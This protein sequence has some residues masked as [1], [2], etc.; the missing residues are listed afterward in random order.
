MKTRLGIAIVFTF[1]LTGCGVI[2]PKETVSNKIIELKEQAFLLNDEVKEFMPNL[3]Q[4]AVE[5]FIYQI[6]NENILLIGID[7]TYDSITEGLTDDESGK[8]VSCYKLPVTFSFT[9]TVEKIEEFLRCLSAVDTKVVMNKFEVT[10]AE[11]GYDVECLVCFIGESATLGIGNNSTALSLVKKDKAVK[12]EEEIVL[13]N[14]DVNLTV[15]PSNS[16]AAAVTLSTEL[17][18]ALRSDEN[19]LIQAIANFYKE[20]GQFYCKYSIG[21]QSQIDKITVGNEVKFDILSCKH[22]LDTDLI[23]VDLAIQNNLSVPVSVVVYN[24]SDNRVKITK[25]GS[26][27]VNRK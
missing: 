24:D 19:G 26:V 20:N 21:D 9:G 11:V 5:D 15:R 16:D 22:K 6:K 8:K 2:E 25:T 17:G 27:E 4:E 7:E 14:F 10:E 12:E 13:R 18:N 3:S 23:S 1:L